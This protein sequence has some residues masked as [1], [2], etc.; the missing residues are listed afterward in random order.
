MD[1]QQIFSRNLKK[2]MEDYHYTQEQLSD[3]IGIGQ[4]TISYWLSGKR[5]PK[6]AML[7]KLAEIFHCTKADLLQEDPQPV[8]LEPFYANYLKLTPE[9]KIL[10]DQL[11]EML[12]NDS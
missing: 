8:Q 3:W 12:L 7:D 2:L 10:I 4:S 5:L 1:S 6:A 9:K 11:V